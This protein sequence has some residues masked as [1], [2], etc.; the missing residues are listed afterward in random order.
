M[1]GLCDDRYWFLIEHIA[2]PAQ[3]IRRLG[4]AAAL[5]PVEL[6]VIAHLFLPWMLIWQ[7][8]T[9]VHYHGEDA[10]GRTVTHQLPGVLCGIE[11]QMGATRERAAWHFLIPTEKLRHF[12]IGQGGET[13]HEICCARV[14]RT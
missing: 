12:L 13:L 11:E 8:T 14:E 10:P 3:R 9:K 7:P 1:S 2:N 6:V 5:R 4:E